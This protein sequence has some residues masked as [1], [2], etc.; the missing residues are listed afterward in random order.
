MSHNE[1]TTQQGL[2]TDVSAGGS[3]AYAP[4]VF[5]P[6]ADGLTIVDLVEQY[7]YT[8]AMDDGVM[9]TTVDVGTFTYPVDAA[10]QVH[11]SEV[12]VRGDVPAIYV[13]DGDWTML[14]ETD[15]PTERRFPAGEYYLEICAPIKLFLHVDGPMTV[16][17]TTEGKAVRFADERPVDVGAFSKQDQPAATVTTTADP[18]DVMAAVS[19]FGSALKTTSPERSFPNQRGHPPTIERGDT[20]AIPDGLSAPETGVTIEVPPALEYVYPVA[21][22][23]YYLGATVVPGS[24]PRLVSTTGF[25]HDLAPAGRFEQEVERVLKGT[26]LLDCVTRTEGLYDVELDVRRKLEPAVDLDFATLYDRPLAERLEAYLDVPYETLAPHVPDWKLTADVAASADSIET[27]PFLAKDLA[28]IRTDTQADESNEDTGEPVDAS[29]RVSAREETNTQSEAVDSFLRR[30]H[31]VSAPTLELVEGAETDS[32]EHVWVGE[33]ARLGASKATATAYRNRLARARTSNDIDVTVVCNDPGMADEHSI[34]DEVYGAN[35]AESADVSI[36]QQLTT[37]ELR[38]E[39]S[40]ECAFFHYIGHID[41]R[42]FECEDGWLDAST[43]ESTGVEVFFLNAC[44]SYSQGM[45]LIDAGA[46]GGIVTLMDVVNESAV[47]IGSTLARLLD[48]GYPLQPALEIARIAI[49][50]GGDYIVVGDSTVPL[51]NDG[52][53]IPNLHKVERDGDEFV[54]EIVSYSTVMGGMGDIFTPYLDGVDQ[55]YLSSGSLDTFR[56]SKKNLRAFLD[57][58]NKPVVVDRK[59]YWPDELD[60]ST[61]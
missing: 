34:V 29:T 38:A 42:G 36:A 20:L 55:Y 40:E 47:R 26:F 43:L 41:D 19:T 28:V 15:P 54:L 56:L 59:L 37:D 61:M 9:P 21:T 46:I 10:V 44:R 48:E 39:L 1:T 4:I 58:D 49:Y 18:R 30:S 23:A 33:G 32:L 60:L 12:A 22:L 51:V 14:A 2:A 53:F 35:D 7:R 57:L 8:L 31:S 50:T 6:V 17:A 3:A 25:D 11:T 24:R 27:L 45:H 52:N 5:H 16:T 13:R